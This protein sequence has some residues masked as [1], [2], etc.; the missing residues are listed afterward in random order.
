MRVL[1]T[2]EGAAGRVALVLHPG[3]VRLLPA[4]EAHQ[5]REAHGAVVARRR[6]LVVEAGLRHARWQRPS[7]HTTT[8]TPRKLYTTHHLR[9]RHAQITL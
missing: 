3:L 6:G 1:A 7:A 2:Y 9:P 5:A 8:T 4:D